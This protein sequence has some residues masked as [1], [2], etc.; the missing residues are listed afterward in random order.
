MTHS[1]NCSC[2][3]DVWDVTDTRQVPP[4]LKYTSPTTCPR[5]WT[6]LLL[7]HLLHFAIYDHPQDTV[8][9]PFAKLILSST[10]VSLTG[11]VATALLLMTRVFVFWS[12][13][14]DTVYVFAHRV[15][16]LHGSVFRTHG[17]YVAKRAGQFPALHRLRNIVE[18]NL[19][20]TV[21]KPC[22]KLL[23]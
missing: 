8:S 9:K 5:W 15:Y 19:H 13:T 16:L 10:T 12:G 2:W 11:R 14:R 23:C 17:V 3:T 7:V 4:I 1:A 22:A 20:D 21:V 18:D 6:L